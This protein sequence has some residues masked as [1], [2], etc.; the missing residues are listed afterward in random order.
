[1]TPASREKEHEEDEEDEELNSFPPMSVGETR[2]VSSLKDKGVTKK[3]LQPSST[4]SH[5]H[6]HPEAGDKVLV[7][8]TGRLLDEAKTKFDSS[9]DRGEPFEFTVGVGQVIKGWDLGVMTMERGEKCLLTCK[10]EYAYGAAG[11]P[12]SIPPNATL[13]FEVELISW[14]SENDLFGDG[15]V[16]RVAKIEDGEGWKTPKDGDWL[17]I[18]VRASRKERET[19]KMS[20]VWEKGLADEGEEEKEGL[21][22]QLNLKKRN[23]KEDADNDD[24]SKVPFGVHLALQFFKKGETQR[25][26]VRNEYLLEKNAPYD[27]EDDELYF[28]VTLKRWVHVEKICNGLGEKTTIK[29]AP[30]SNYDTPNEGAKVVFSSVKVYRGKRDFA[31]R[32]RVGDQRKEE[33]EEAKDVVFASKE[34]EEFIYEIG[35]DDDDESNASIIVSACEEGIQRMRAEETA[36]IVLPTDFAFGTSSSDKGKEIKKTFSNGKEISSSDTPFVTYVFEMKSMER[37]K[38]PWAL[39]GE[40]KVERAEKLKSSGNAFFKKKEYARAEAKYSQ[41]L[42]YVEP[43][44]QQKEETANKIKALKV[45]LHLNYAACA[46][47]RFAWKEVV[48]NCDEVLKIESLNEKAL[49]R[50]ATAEIEFELYD[51]ARRTIKTLVEDVTS[52][53]PTSASETLRLKQRLKQKE[54]TQRKK[55]SKVFGGMFSKLDLFTEDERNKKPK[56]DEEK[57]DDAETALTGLGEMMKGSGGIGGGG[58]IDANAPPPLPLEDLPDDFQDYGA[59]EAMAT[60]TFPFEE[61]KKKL[62]EGEQMSLETA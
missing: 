5:H 17:E 42:R 27:D 18:G 20:T 39:T 21:F 12:P 37:A 24:A 59:K 43:D 2:D 8:Y 31:R 47:K 16:I 28:T 44:G 38:D 60:D 11:A 26:L 41:G 30:E 32:G 33:E 58:G 1:M 7:H 29:E 50:K 35:G 23:G 22:F 13:E 55:D 52:P 25:L 19:G 48:V 15:G 36:Q 53:S 51:E 46:L 45:S 4:P 62:E 3:L 6:K 9:V 34:G 14:K 56:S 10:P 49:Y 54:A 40:E 61:E 57:F